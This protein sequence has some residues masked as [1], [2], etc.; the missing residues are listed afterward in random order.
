MSDL[1]FTGFG[2]L[3][4]AASTYGREDHPAVILLPGV[5]QTRHAWRDA[6]RAL[7]SA[8]RYVICLDLRGHG[9]SE[10]PSDGNYRLDAFV[11]D[12][13]AVLA[14][15]S[16]RPAIVGSTFGGWIAL[17]ALGEATSPL[18]SGLVLTNP[19]RDLN[20]LD[21][22]A[23]DHELSV[24][25]AKNSGERKFDEAIYQGGFDFIELESR[26]KQAAEKLRVPA[27]IVRGEDNQLSSDEAATSLVELVPDG[28]L[29]TMPSGGHYLAFERSDEFNAVLL[30]FLERKVPR[31]PPEYSSGEDPR[32][33]RDAMGCFA[34]GITVLTTKAETGDPVGL[35][36]N[37][38]TSVSLDPPLVLVCLA[39]TVRSLPAFQ[40]NPA[41]AINIL[42]TGQQPVSNLFA[43]KGQDRFANLEWEV[44]SH[45][46]PIIP[47]SLA[48]FECKR[49]NEIEQ[50]DHI[51]LV[52][53]VVR[54]RYEARKDPLLY[55]GGQY[56]RLHFG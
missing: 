10:R 1:V 25:A 52:G 40:S 46:V 45:D 6:A 4:L 26:M 15:L 53:E 35:T 20:E 12:L 7:A 14:Q 55:F 11:A 38:F 30:A 32:T 21:A 36:A 33:L 47:S 17:T 50:G 5:T 56:R 23:V 13:I 54:A 27:L 24:A 9:D 44:W 29:V 31:D 37:S 28:E 42:H 34:S 8:G 43:S 16:S 22:Q 41:F 19:F 49:V 48:S 39:K 18:A 51:I 2:G 3:R